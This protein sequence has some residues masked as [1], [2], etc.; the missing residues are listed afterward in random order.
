MKVALA[1]PYNPLEEIG[2]LELGTLRHATALSKCGCEA[3]ILT[4]GASSVKE[5]VAIR[6]FA[7]L[8]EMCRWLLAKPNRYDVVHWLEIF[9]NQ[10]EVEIQAMCSCLLRSFGTKVVFMVAT[11]GNLKT[12]GSGPLATPLIQRSADV[13]IVSNPE[14]LTEFADSG[15]RKNVRVIGFGVDTDQQF[16]PAGLNEKLGLRAFLGLPAEKVLCLFMGRFVERKRPDFLL[17]NWQAM[18]RLHG[19]AELVVVGSGMGQHDSIETQLVSLAASTPYTIFKDVT[20]YPEHYYRAC[21]LL[22]L[23]SSREGQPNVLMEMMACGNPVVGSDIPGIRELLHHGVTGLL[24]P[25]DNP[26]AFREAVSLLVTDG[27]LRERLGRAAR[28]KITAEK[29]IE[30]VTQTYLDLYREL[31]G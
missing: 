8:V 28:S 3:E 26:C 9:P 23:P 24:F 16:Y 14:Q 12:R 4:K 2:G 31:G 6:G 10:G 30:S 19:S 7:D 13:Y 21:D 25:A 20:E 18:E 11:S 27:S 5:G 22:L 29:G 17:R 1:I 15:I